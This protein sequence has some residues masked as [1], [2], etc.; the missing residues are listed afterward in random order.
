MRTVGDAR[1]AVRVR[2]DGDAIVRLDC[3]LRHPD[4]AALQGAGQ[5]RQPCRRSPGALVGRASPT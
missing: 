5:L 2:P 3:D 4:D 1:S